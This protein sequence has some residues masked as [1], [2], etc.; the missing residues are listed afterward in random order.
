M[1][2]GPKEIANN[3]EKYYGAYVD[4]AATY[5]STDIE[6]K[7]DAIGSVGWQIF[8]ADQNN[9]YLIADDYINTIYLEKSNNILLNGYKVHA[10]SQNRK[11]LLDYLNTEKNWNKLKTSKAINVKGA[12]TLEQFINSYNAKHDT[13]LFYKINTQMEDGINGYY[14]GTTEDP[15]SYNIPNINENSENLYFLKSD[16]A[17]RYWLA[18]GSARVYTHVMAI[19]KDEIGYT[20]CT[21]GTIGVRPI[22]CLSSEIELIKENDYFR[23]K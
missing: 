19:S 9:I 13:K 18:S 2:I 23:I 8:Y 14:V 4:Y 17:T 22:V 3:P 6:A 15:D 1:G 21:D 12:P 5:R 16:K 11:L 10:D 20:D 7:S